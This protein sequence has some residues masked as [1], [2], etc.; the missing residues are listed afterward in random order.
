MEKS[1][2]KNIHEFFL[3]Y[4]SIEISQMQINS[5]LNSY[6][7]NE[8]LDEHKFLSVIVESGGMLSMA[9]VAHQI[10]KKEFDDFKNNISVPVLLFIQTESGIR[11]CILFQKNKILTQLIFEK[12]G[13][14]T[15]LSNE[16]LSLNFSSTNNNLFVTT[17]FP[18]E[19]ELY[20]EFENNDEGIKK[21]LTPFQRLLKILNAEKKEITYIYLYA[22][23]GGL[24]SLSLPLGIQSIIGFISSGAIS[25]SVIILIAFI[26][27]GILI[28][29]MLQIAQVS[30]V[31]YIQQRI[32]TKT[33]LEF[34]FRI[35][36][37]KSESLFTQ[38]AQEL[39]NRF[40]DIITVQKGLAKILVEFSTAVLQILFGLIILALY[41]PYFI[42]LGLILIVIL[43]LLLKYTGP[44][45]LLTS[46]RESKY[47]YMVANWLEEVARTQKT[48]KLA[49]SS[50]LAIE[51]TDSNVS[52]YLFNRKKHFK[53]LITQYLGFI[54]FKT[55][56]TGGL[57]IMGCVLIVNKQINIGQFVASEI[58]II[59]IMNSVEKIILSLD[60]VYDILTSL[61]KISQVTDLPLEYSKGIR[62]REKTDGIKVE[63][64][65]AKFAYNKYSDDV[66]KNISFTIE[67]G[68]TACIA[69]YNSSGKTTLINLI[70][71]T[72]TLKKGNVLINDLDRKLLHQNDFLKVVGNNLSHEEIFDGTLEEN[73]NMGDK[74]I[75][76][77]NILSVIKEIGLSN[78]LSS[79][80]DGLDTRLIR[81]S[82]SVS[83]SNAKKI[84]LAR[85]LVKNPQLLVLD[86]F[87]MG[88]EKSEKIRL[89]ESIIN[90]SKKTTIII[91]ND[92][93][94]MKLCD[95]VIILKD[96]E[97][98]ALG[99]YEEIKNNELF[100]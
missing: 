3:N 40:F 33:A 70:L 16:N 48:F 38:N 84:I 27:L 26:I 18:L 75:S 89:F 60:V 52:N 77:D 98:N 36:K 87:L 69:G 28:S 35:P 43:F 34:A 23:V 72:F 53:I 24:I 1:T 11:P 90:R 30:I 4:N 78:M 66:I 41:H 7:T 95:K 46:N 44:K 45:G 55:V 19:K 94:V 8:N 54:G 6:K 39:M 65:N 64:K 76:R 56:I 91:S 62:L 12:E 74:S 15:E 81:G 10:D 2:L 14:V 17:C 21:S 37:I 57:L 59:L 67:K 13:N 73:I 25:T 82:K 31:E 22:I 51:K 79:L 71:G 49:G 9:Y 93:V 29:G 97:I 47:K 68:E 80:E 32:F 99:R 85:S 96:G 100:N 92:P 58:I 20:E 88:V 61:D 5:Y 42:F 50:N 63:V 86:D 83:S